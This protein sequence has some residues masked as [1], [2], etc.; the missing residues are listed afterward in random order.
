MAMVERLGR[1]EC[2][3][4]ELIEVE[5]GRPR[6]LSGPK[7]SQHLSVLKNA[8]VIANEKR[9]QKIFY[10]LLMPCVAEISLCTK[11]LETV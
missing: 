8:G 5:V 11:E 7:I 6:K 1:G 9:G 4:C 3:V 2:C 10:H